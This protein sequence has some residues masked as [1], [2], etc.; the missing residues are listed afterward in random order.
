MA[1]VT[2]V[3]CVFP[4]VVAFILPHTEFGRNGQEKGASCLGSANLGLVES[5]RSRRKHT[6]LRDE[7]RRSFKPKWTILR[8]Q[9]IFDQ[10]SRSRHF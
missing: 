1:M 3:G 6:I 2:E 10:K 7:S 9:T 5:R 4:M 8:K